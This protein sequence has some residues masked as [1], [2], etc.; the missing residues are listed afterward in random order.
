MGSELAFLTS[1]AREIPQSFKVKPVIQVGTLS[2][3]SNG[4]KVL[5]LL[6]LGLARGRMEQCWDS[7][8]VCVCLVLLC[9][10][11]P[12][13]LRSEGKDKVVVSMQSDVGEAGT[14]IT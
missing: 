6:K 1:Q 14:D 10:P 11:V 4:W 5:E 7:T 8:G 2:T 9:F 13:V 12:G 3:R